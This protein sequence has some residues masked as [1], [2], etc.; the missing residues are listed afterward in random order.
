MPPMSDRT[1]LII[2]N[3]MKDAPRHT[4]ATVPKRSGNGA[5]EMNPAAYPATLL[6]TESSRNDSPVNN[7]PIANFV[8]V[9][10]SR[11]PSLIHNHA[12]AGASTI[13]NNACTDTNQLD[14][15]VKPNIVVLL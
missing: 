5:D 14:G 1:G 12:N 15:N 8:V 9:D 11:C 7:S 2:R 4:A 10:G 6:P 13:T 3:A